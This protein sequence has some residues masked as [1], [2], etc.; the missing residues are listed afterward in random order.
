MEA[1]MVVIGPDVRPQIADELQTILL[2]MADDENGR[3]ALAQAGIE[4]FV[5][6]DDAVYD[7]V[8]QLETAVNP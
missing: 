8:R 2:Q 7:S 1:L 6:V 3:L 4:Q 5:L